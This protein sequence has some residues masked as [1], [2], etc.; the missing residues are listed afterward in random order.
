VPISIRLALGAL[1]LLVG[2][3]LLTVAVLGGRSRLRRNRWAGVRTA[4]TMRSE[5]A[6][7]LANRV[8]AAPLG[9]AGLV[10]AAGGGLL[11][12]GADGA[13]GWVLLAISGVAALVLAGLGGAAGDRAATTAPAP[14]A[15]PGCAGQCA[16][17][18]LVAGCRPAAQGAE[19]G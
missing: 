2:L 14:A 19:R 12:G 18:D 1:E 15:E 11:L 8:A 4:A 7:A 6:F 5:E 3:G 17:C 10:A 9:A 16:G 13:A